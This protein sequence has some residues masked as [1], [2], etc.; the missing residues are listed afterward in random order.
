M[1]KSIE[2]HTFELRNGS[3]VVI[4]EAEPSNARELIV[5][6]N[7]VAEESDY[8]TLRPGD[9]KLT[10]VEEAEFLSKCQAIKNHVYLVAVIESNIVGTVHFSAGQK[11]R[12]R[13]S[14]EF[15]MS[16]SKQYWG[17]GIG[18][19]MLDTL[20]DWAKQTNIDWAKQTN[21][22][23]KINLRV[24]TDNRRAVQLYRK[25]GFQEEGILS[26]EMFVDGYYYDLYAMGLNF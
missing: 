24:R 6:V 23:R 19:L 8:L 10:E 25:K 2:P 21:I 18:S 3:S 12:I 1:S 20:I 7:R 26:N 9:F 17:Q 22:I 5:F 13:H 16:V 15:G 4:R 11:I 14:G